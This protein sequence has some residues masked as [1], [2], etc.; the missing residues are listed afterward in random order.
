MHKLL[1]ACSRQLLLHSLTLSCAFM[2]AS[3]TAGAL[4]VAILAADSA[5]KP[6]DVQSK[7]L[8]TGKFH[9]ID[10]ID[11]Q[12]TTP[13]FAQL[14][15]YGSVLVYK[16]WT[17]AD[18]TSLGNTLADYYDAGGGVVCTVF[19]TAS[20]RYFLGGRWA[21]GPYHALARGGVQ[22]TYP[23]LNE[24]GGVYEPNHPVMDGVTT[25]TA[26]G[27]PN[28]TGLA[29]GAIRI[30]DYEGGF[31]L[32]A[33][34]PYL[35]HHI[36]DLGFFAP[37]TDVTVNAAWTSATD[38]DLLMANALLYVASP[39]SKDDVYNTTEDTPLSVPAPGV[40]SNDFASSG[41]QAIAEL[42]SG[43]ANGALSLQPDGSFDY[44][45][46]ANFNGVDFFTYRIS[47]GELHSGT[48]TVQ[49]Q[50]G[51]T[52]DAPLAAQDYFT[53]VE[54]TVLT[55]TAPG[56]LANDI[57]A[58]ND[59]L[60][61]A[62]VTPPHSGHLFLNSDGSLA[63]VPEPDFSG[64]DQFTY[65]ASDGTFNSAD[66]TVTITV[67]P[68]A[69]APDAEA[70]TYS[71]DED[72]SLTITA[73]GVLGN[74]FDADGDPL[75][76]ELVA[77]T[78]HG[79]LTLN[80]DGSFNYVPAPDYFGSD[81]FTY[82][83]SDGTLQ[84]APVTVT[85]TV[86]PINDLPRANDDYFSA[87][88]QHPLVVSAPGVLGNDV[89]PESEQ[90]SAYLVDAP[91]SGS[92][93]LAS[94]GSF[95]YTPD[96]YFNGTDVFHYMANDSH[97][98]STTATVTISVVP[99]NDI[100]V[101]VN[102]QYFTSE[103][104]VLRVPAANGVLI[105]DNDADHDPLI[106]RLISQPLHGTLNL[107]GDGSFEY[108]AAV[109]FQGTDTFTY[110]AND[111]LA[112]SAIATVSIVV[113]PIN[114]GPLAMPDAFATHEDQALY[115]AAPGVLSND[116]DNDDEPLASILLSNPSHGII[117]LQ[118]DGSFL[119][120]PTSNFTGFDEFL[121]KVNDGH[122]ES[123]ATSVTISIGAINDAPIAADD[124]YFT[125]E[126]HTL[127]VASAG[128]LSNDTDADAADMLSA[129]LVTP[130]LH[131]TLNFHPDGTFIYTPEPLFRGMDS[132]VYRAYDG[133][134]LSAP[135]TAVITVA[136]Q[137]T[138]PVLSNLMATS[139]V[140][141][142]TATVSGTITDPNTS[143]AH[144]VTILWGDNTA[145]TIVD[146]NPGISIFNISRAFAD[147]NPTATPI[148]THQV[149]VIVQDGQG[150]ADSQTVP[151]T[152]AN[153]AP[154]LFNIRATPSPSGNDS[155][156]LSGDFADPG[157]ADT[158]DLQ[159]NWGDDSP[160]QSLHLFADQ[161]HFELQHSYDGNGEKTIQ[162]VLVD[163]D[164]GVAVAQLIISKDDGPDQIHS[165]D[166]TATIGALSQKCKTHQGQ[167][168]CSLKAQVM[169]S[170]TGDQSAPKSSVALYLSTNDTLDSGDTYLKSMTIKPL[171]SG[172]GHTAKV[173]AKLPEG[174]SPTGMYLIAISD[175]G[176][177]VNETNESNNT[178][179]FGPLP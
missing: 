95:T 44:T 70:D 113:G 155:L 57:D 161:R 76:A 19:E 166:L 148:D 153:V 117:T 139:I 91:L 124:N 73:P 123:A 172:K 175:P 13:T 51:G 1:S 146:L 92:L 24:I 82:S 104:T 59:P 135:A 52:G 6:Q 144:Q 157:L 39:V 114:D 62:L 43:P 86:T 42:V 63:Y 96:T 27:R 106:V 11:V 3:A 9:S 40:L 154:Q 152:V 88:E 14:Q 45:P 167:P 60:S 22:F 142:A 48:A 116:V 36:I 98:N 170:N 103:D 75:N 128:V 41:S 31:P 87:T 160:T 61:A 38:G 134:A 85:I 100:P 47:A 79:I 138:A 74:D 23:G 121:Y 130:P 81:S 137:N 72:T 164:G 90:L 37:S 178:Y 105:N 169:V 83:A 110:Q 46:A 174:T 150:G 165:P 118:S 78:Q 56:V 53:A 101:A 132:F 30:A 99:H 151:L 65:R 17:Y 179:S 131:G 171:P 163:D 34:K 29:A 77:S 115:I 10:I 69:D 64:T 126:N 143:D 2:V 4:D 26:G 89:D 136:A 93:T 173:N 16:N 18:S 109:N 28:Y 149:Q 168:R 25:F 66:T 159:V 71:L 147:D 125:W 21:S 67:Q 107:S 7:L 12:H 122:T 127:T 111:G 177:Q 49:I 158:F 156:I 141:G 162:V 102:D 20:N 58:D 97:G 35:G 94:D 68:V 80:S 145:P 129:Q 33:A 5:P 120:T 55:V 140:E 54:D 8:A 50:V 15:S 84:S 32:V 133:T 119:Y 108:T 112:D 176:G